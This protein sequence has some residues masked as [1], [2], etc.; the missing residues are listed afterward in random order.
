MNSRTAPEWI[1]ARRKRYRRAAWVWKCLFDGP[2]ILTPFLFWALPHGS[3]SELF[4]FRSVP[5]RV[6][7]VA[8]LLMSV[9]YELLRVPD[10]VRNLREAADCLEIAIVRYEVSSDLPDTALLEADLQAT[11]LLQRRGSRWKSFFEGTAR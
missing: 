2:L 4:A 1:T 7:A 5:V 8:L 3:I 9:A 6:V 11:A 10:R